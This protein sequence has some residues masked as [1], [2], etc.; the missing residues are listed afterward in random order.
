MYAQAESA[1]VQKQVLRGF[2]TFGTLTI[3]DILELNQGTL[4]GEYHC[5]VDLLFDK[6]GISSMTTENFRFYLQKRLIQTGQTGVQL[7]SDTT[8]SV[9]PD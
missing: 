6:F 3:V 2:Y 5:T 7:Y 9:F 4:K 1:G 8:P